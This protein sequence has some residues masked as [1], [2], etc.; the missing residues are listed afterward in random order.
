MIVRPRPVRAGEA[1]AK[2]TLRLPGV[3]CR[4]APV[5]GPAVRLRPG[6]VADAVVNRI[7]EVR[8]ERL[9]K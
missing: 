9:P 4:H 5:H 6:N 7:V 8:M 2:A 1:G 3:R